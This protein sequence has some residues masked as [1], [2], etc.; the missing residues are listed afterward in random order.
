VGQPPPSLL[1]R[2]EEGSELLLLLLL[3]LLCSVLAGSRVGVGGVGEEEGGVE[4]QRGVDAE[5]VVQVLWIGWVGMTKIERKET[6][7]LLPPPPCL[8]LY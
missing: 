6:G 8:L 7:R 3:L 2:K 5:A 1:Q 4:V